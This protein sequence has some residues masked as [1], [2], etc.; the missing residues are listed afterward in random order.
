M[1]IPDAKLAELEALAPKAHDAFKIAHRLITHQPREPGTPS[2]M[3]I[4]AD[5]ARDAD[6]ILAAIT[7]AAPD[8]LADLREAN[9]AI[10][11]SQGVNQAYA[12][13]TNA[14]V[15]RADKA[16]ADLRDARKAAG[17]NWAPHATLADIVFALRKRGDEAEAN[18]LAKHR[19]EAPLRT[20]ARL[21]DSYKAERDRFRDAYHLTRKFL[22]EAAH[23]VESK[24]FRRRLNAVLQALDIQV[25]SP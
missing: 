13:Q 4:P 21:S 8:L 10:E 25:L 15:E 16:E 2:Y 17:D 18:Y 11:F 22:A 7:E 19:E 9:A 3:S 20:A 1:R 5:P 12:D 6:L 23:W 24:E 14:A